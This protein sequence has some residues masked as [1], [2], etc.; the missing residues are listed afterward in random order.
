MIWLAAMIA[1]V[2]RTVFI[3]DDT[4]NP[5]EGD[6]IGLETA[7]ID[8]ETLTQANK[9]K[10]DEVLKLLVGYVDGIHAMSPADLRIVATVGS[11]KLWSGTIHNSA[12]SN[13]T[14]AQFLAASG[15][16]WVTKGDVEANSADGDFGAFVGL[17]RGI[18]GAGIAAVWDSGALIVD[19]Y[20]GA[21][22]GTVGLTLNY[23]WDFQFP[24]TANFKRLKYVA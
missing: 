2:D 6:I 20:T 24:R 9:V 19:P 16:N 8:E 14:I 23:L 12:A 5:N 1:T 17:G 22:G 18:D 7:S 3:G 13:Q 11:N 21:K 4:A 10:A 15:I